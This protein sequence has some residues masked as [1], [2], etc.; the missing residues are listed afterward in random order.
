MPIHN[1]IDNSFKRI[2]D[3]HRLFAD[4]LKDFIHIDILENVQPEDI[5]DLTER[6]LPLF[7]ENRDADTVK[8]VRL[9]DFEYPPV[10]PMVLYD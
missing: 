8:R 3:D 7:Q 6:F 5:E 10:L 9:K 1:A 4:F 2:F